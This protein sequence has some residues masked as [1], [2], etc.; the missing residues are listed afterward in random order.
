MESPQSKRPRTDQRGT[1]K[2]SSETKPSNEDLLKSGNPFMPMF[3]H[4]RDELDEHHD[5]RERVIKTS[6]DVTALSKKLIFSLQR[7]RQLNSPIPADLEDETSSRL[8]E[9]DKLLNA[10]S[11]DLQSINAH[12]YQRNISGGLQE[13]MEAICFRH[14]I[15]T[16]RLL[17]YA[18]AQAAVPGGIDLTPQ[19]YVLGVFDFV[20]EVMR[21]GITM[22]AL[23]G[24]GNPGNPESGAQRILLDLRNLR[25][26]FK[27]LDGYLGK[28]VKQ[29]MAVMEACVAKVENAVYTVIVRGSEYPN[30]RIPDLGSTNDPPPEME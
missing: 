25:E 4:F 2:T 7:C 6:R 17:S 3:L 22:V 19:D 30:G 20:G 16:G 8:A 24:P 5:R 9:I 12:R 23:S 26:A 27:N 29:K 18:E 15:V 13:F 28:D 14:Y 10:V 1:R 11:P 21:F